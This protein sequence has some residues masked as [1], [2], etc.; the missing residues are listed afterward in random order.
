[1]L[2]KVKAI[3]YGKPSLPVEDVVITDALR[4]TLR[5]EDSPPGL[6]NRTAA[7]VL[8]LFEAEGHSVELVKNY[9]PNGDNYSGVNCVL[10][11]PAG[12]RW[13]L[14]F[15]TAGSLKTNLANRDAYEEL[16]RVNTALERKRDLFDTMSARW[17]RVPIPAGILTPRSLH[18]REKIIQRPR[19]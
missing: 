19:P 7:K 12:L 13:E 4:Y 5:V 6:H 8:A 1:M 9:W 2:R 14:Q 3:R 11:T 16:R 15:H 18:A 17:A 10:R